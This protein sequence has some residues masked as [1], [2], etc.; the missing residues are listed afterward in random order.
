MYI[1]AVIIWAVFDMLENLCEKSMLK[2]CAK[3][4][5][6]NL[7]LKICAEICAENLL[8]IICAENLC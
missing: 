7:M 4:C 2:I 5:A 8:L 3:I 6:E 1:R